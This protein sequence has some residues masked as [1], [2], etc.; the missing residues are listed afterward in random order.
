MKIL[1]SPSSFQRWRSSLPIKASIGFVPTMGALHEAHLSLIKRSKRENKFTVVSIF[2]NP[3][4]FG[5]RE[6]F[7]RYP[8]PFK[9]DVRLLNSVGV[10][11]LF[12][13]SQDVMY[14]SNHVTEVRVKK[15]TNT[16]CGAPRS[17]GPQHFVGVATVVAKLFNIVRPHKAYF[18]MKDF[19]QLRMIE[20]MT[21]DLNWDVKIIR[22]P[23][24]READGLARSSRNVF[25]SPRERRQAPRLFQALQ[26]GR[27][28]LTSRAHMSPR[29]ICKKISH[30]LSVHPSFKID[31][32]EMVDPATLEPMKVRRRPALLAAAVFM[33]RTRLIDNILIKP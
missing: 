16:L 25:L 29:A 9:A 26:Q 18:G 30:L 20:Q 8:R 11:V 12:A 33:G 15:L 27:K 7:K 23:T 32:I 5:P 2:V 21:E 3:T 19:Q 13:P 4:Q 17:R 28:L 24:L 6:D 22:C 14:G 10:D 1:Y 31:Y